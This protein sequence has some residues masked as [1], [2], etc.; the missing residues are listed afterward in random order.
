VPLLER[1][2]SLRDRLVAMSNYVAEGR[3]RYA[4][5]IAN[6]PRARSCAS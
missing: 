5:E 2:F 6:S 3:A 1:S 4:R